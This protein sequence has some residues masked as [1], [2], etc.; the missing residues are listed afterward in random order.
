MPQ[1]AISPVNI[2]I[3]DGEVVISFHLHGELNVLVADK[4]SQP[5]RPLEPNDKSVIHIMEPAE[6]P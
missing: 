4:D 5:V 2:Y 3:Q 1:T 6:P